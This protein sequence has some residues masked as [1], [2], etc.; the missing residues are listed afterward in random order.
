[1][2][3]GLTPHIPSLALVSTLQYPHHPFSSSLSPPLQAPQQHPSP[4]PPSLPCINSPEG[5][6]E[7]EAAEKAAPIEPKAKA[8]EKEIGIAAPPPMRN[9][10]QQ[11]Q[12]QQHEED[13]DADDDEDDSFPPLAHSSRPC[14]FSCML[15]P[16][17]APSLADSRASSAHSSQAGVG[18]MFS[19]GA[20]SG[21]LPLPR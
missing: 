20:T 21:D 19:I 8:A 14:S 13:D 17:P 16:T 2:R 3:S 12:Q 1:M 7:A 4:A 5:E 9:L 6:G 10:Q 18:A 11:L 15:P